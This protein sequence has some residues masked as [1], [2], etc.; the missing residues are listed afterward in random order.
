MS[1]HRKLGRKTSARMSILRNLTT[2]LIVG[3]YVVTTVDRAKEVRSIAEQLIT[4]AVKEADNYKTRE[5]L[6]SAAK[7]DSKGKKVL[8][9]KTSA[10]GKKYYAVDRELKTQEVQVDDPSRLAVRRRA[11]NWLVRT[12][13][14]DGQVVNPVNYLF[15]EVAPKYKNRQGGY[16]RI[17]QL[18]ARRGD[19]AEMCRL[20]LV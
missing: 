2:Q 16:T 13:D 15:D 7:V 1:G 17:I 4:D 18:G 5:V 8:T 12:K 20:E 9:E 3:G 6:V 11:M 19:S 10:N 14:A